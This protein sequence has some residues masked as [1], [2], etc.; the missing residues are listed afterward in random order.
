MNAE[1]YSRQFKHKADGNDKGNLGFENRIQWSYGSIEEKLNWNEGE[2]ENLNNP[3]EIIMN[4]AE[5]RVP[6]LE[7]KVDS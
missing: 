4:Q 3:R 6:G 2:I 7:D 1:W 5:D